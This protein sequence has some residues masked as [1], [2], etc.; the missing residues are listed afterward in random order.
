MSRIC[1][2][3][4]DFNLIVFWA[5]VQLFEVIETDKTLYL[6]MEYA[7]G[8]ESRSRYVQDEMLMMMM[9]VTDLVEQR[10]VNSG[11]TGNVCVMRSVF[12]SND[13]SIL[14]RSAT[15]TKVKR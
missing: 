3:I 6:I 10:C 1:L 8:G 12:G 14:M 11:P 9:K 4:F 2:C 13:C 5:T 7:S 15:V